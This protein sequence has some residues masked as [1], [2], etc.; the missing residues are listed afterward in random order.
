MENK[1]LNTLTNRD[2]F[3]GDVKIIRKAKPGPVVFIVTNGLGAI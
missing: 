1:G 2:Y 3:K